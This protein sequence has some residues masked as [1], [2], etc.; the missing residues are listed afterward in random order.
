M[1]WISCCPIASARQH[2]RFSVGRL[3]ARRCLTGLILL[4]VLACTADPA[5]TADTAEERARIRSTLGYRLDADLLYEHLT[6]NADYGDWHSL[7]LTFTVKTLPRVTPF[8]WAGLYEREDR[9]GAGG[10]GA[11]MDWLPWLYTYTATSFAGLSNYHTRWRLDHF[12]NVKLE[13]MTWAMGGG[14]MQS[15]QDNK[16]WFLAA[17]PRYWNGP[18]ILEYRLFRHASDPGNHVNWQHLWSFG[19]G[20]EGRRWFFVTA[21]RGGEHYLAMWVDPHQVIDRDAWEVS[22]VWQQWLTARAGY[23]L[24][25]SFLDLGEPGDG[26]R[27]YSFGVGGFWEF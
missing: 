5:A 19:Y 13:P 14:V 22:A 3:T 21:T 6:P 17:G 10:A 4:G 11:Y 8:A 23:K 16:D 2:H 1:S 7:W 12:F 18:L 27:K 24:R 26:Y 9:I 15:H 25:A 20:V